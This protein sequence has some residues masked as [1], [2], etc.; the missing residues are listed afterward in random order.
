M[1]VL[2]AL[3]IISAGN[4]CCC[5]WV[6]SGGVIAAYLLPA[7]HADADHAGRRRARRPARR[8]RRRARALRSSRFRSTSSSRRWSRRCVQRLLDMGTLPPEMRDMLERYGRGGALGGACARHRPHRRPDVLAVRRRRLLDARRP[9]RRADLQEADAA[10]PP[11]STS[12]PH[13]PEPLTVLRSAARALRVAIANRPPNRNSVT[14]SVSGCWCGRRCR[15]GA[16]GAAQRRRSG[17]APMPTLP[18]TQLDERALAAD[19]D[20]RTFTLTFAQPVPVRD[21]LLLL[22]RG[23]SLSIVPDPA[24]GGIVHRRAEERHRAPGARPDPARRSAST[25]RVDGSFVRVFRREPETRIFDLNYI[26]TERAGTTIVGGDGGA[27]QRRERHRARPRPTC[28][29]IWPTA[30]GRC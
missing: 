21:L 22:V 3:P 23:T 25:T 10:V 4:A 9:A 7:E 24:I 5:L 15:A 2:S 11:S 28:S 13:L 12:P 16:A 8:P 14:W 30:C 6:V 17:P 27:R 18:L 29:T 19:L 1:G 20:N 26:A